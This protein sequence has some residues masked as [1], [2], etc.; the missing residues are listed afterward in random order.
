MDFGDLIGYL[1]NLTLQ[2]AQANRSALLAHQE[3]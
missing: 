3:Q 2:K 1:A